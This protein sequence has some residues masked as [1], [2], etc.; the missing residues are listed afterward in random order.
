MTKEQ[1]EHAAIDQI[2]KSNRKLRA[3]K[4]EVLLA[5]SEASYFI[6]GAE[7]RQSEIEEKQSENEALMYKYRESVCQYDLLLKDNVQLQAEIDELFQALILAH[8][9]MLHYDNEDKTK[10]YEVI[11]KYEK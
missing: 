8:N 6:A 2:L 3:Y 4:D 10:V 11:K 7:S 5:S 1:I 9:Y